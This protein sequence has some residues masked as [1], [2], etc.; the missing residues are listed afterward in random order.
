M[1][2]LDLKTF[3][4]L[5]H[6]S[7]PVISA[8]NRLGISDPV[9]SEYA[10]KVLTCGDV[11]TFKEFQE[12]AE[13]R[14]YQA[15]FCKSRFC[16]LCSEITMRKNLLS[17]DLI[18]RF[19]AHKTPKG[20]FLFGTLTVNDILPESLAQSVKDLGSAWSILQ[21][22]LY[23]LKLSN[24]RPYF[25][26]FH[27]VLEITYHYKRGQ[28]VFHPHLHFIAHTDPGYL[29]IV[30]S[31][32]GRSAHAA[33][34]YE[35]P[36]CGKRFRV[37]DDQLSVYQLRHMWWQICRQFDLFSGSRIVHLELCGSDRLLQRDL[38]KNKQLSISSI[39]RSSSLALAQELVKQGKYDFAKS[40]VEYADKGVTKLHGLKDDPMPLYWLTYALKGIRV[41]RPSGSFRDAYK[42][43]GDPE[44]NA[45]LRLDPDKFCIDAKYVILTYIY[46]HKRRVYELQ[47]PDF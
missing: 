34:H 26:G 1:K 40:L 45:A 28:L 30:Q 23:R 8:Y 35:Y 6:K 36:G 42:K 12:T 31:K 27:C 39:D 17:L 47:D 22:R 21:K 9:M 43:F 13:T 33:Y 37:Y 2:P 24:A 38:A 16:P 4:A 20:R 15:F 41:F 3:T 14:F 11:L 46:S 25:L 29:P 18:I 19:L 44:F 32:S 10:Y 7:Y 5:K